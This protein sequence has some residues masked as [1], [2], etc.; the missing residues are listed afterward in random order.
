MSTQKKPPTILLVEDVEEIR[1]AAA[2]LLISDGYRVI[3][4]RDE[5]DALV[6]A[7]RQHPNIL[8]VNLP[9]SYT[10]V[11]QIARRI[12]ERAALSD[13]V[14]ILIFDVDTIPEGSEREMPRN[15]HLARPDN[16]DQL[17]ES[18]CRLLDRVPFPE[19]H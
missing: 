5:E 13:D 6:R 10:A 18:I 4:A 3:P 15:I 1:D 2:E 12:R 19:L 8:L 17:R 9:G 7:D 14:P 16:F 11:L